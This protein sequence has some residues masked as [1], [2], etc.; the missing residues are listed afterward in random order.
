M[1]RISHKTRLAKLEHKQGVKPLSVYSQSLPFKEWLTYQHQQST[2]NLFRLKLARFKQKLTECSDWTDSTEDYEVILSYLR[3]A[4]DNH[5]LRWSTKLFPCMHSLDQTSSL[6]MLYYHQTSTDNA[7]H[8]AHVKPVTCKD[9]DISHTD[10]SGTPL[11][12][13]A[14][15]FDVCSSECCRSETLSMIC[16]RPQNPCGFNNLAVYPA[17]C[18]CFSQPLPKWYRLVEAEV[19]RVTAGREGDMTPNRRLRASKCSVDQNY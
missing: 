10:H 7:E 1:K 3:Y 12:C 11:A 8:P 6:M 14:A 19:W 17:E 2:C 13:T 18:V 15:N 4:E 16:A 9:S 5:A